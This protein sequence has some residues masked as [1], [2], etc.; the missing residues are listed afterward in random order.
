M[1]V[2]F[3]GLPG[4]GKS[5]KLGQK[6]LECFVI[7]ERNN[8]KSGGLLQRPIWSNMIFTQKVEEAFDLPPFDR[9]LYR[10]VKER[11][12]YA[13]AAWMIKE[14]NKK[15]WKLKYW[16]ERLDL[17]KIRHADIF[18]DEEQLYFD[19]QEW[20]MMSRQEKR[21]FQQHRRYGLNIYSASQDFAQVDKSIRRVTQELYY[22]EKVFGSADISSNLPTPRWIYGLSLMYKMD[23]TVYDETISKLTMRWPSSFQWISKKKTEIFDTTEEIIAGEYAPLRKIVRV[24]PED[25]YKKIKYV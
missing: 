23:P 1:K 15:T 16:G 19:N 10:Q 14:Y 25:G 12:E 7:N 3:T 11:E 17:V 8:K 9:E 21:F 2:S 4:S 24:C 5:M 20:E 18:I 6:A 13:T 22:F